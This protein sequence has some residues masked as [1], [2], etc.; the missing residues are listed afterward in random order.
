[1]T[2]YDDFLHCLD[3]IAD[4]IDWVLKENEK[5]NQRLTEWIK[6][7]YKLQ[8]E[9]KKLK[10]EICLLKWKNSDLDS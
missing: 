7:M 10:E 8:E 5:R 4:Y 1:M 9:N 3:L 2:N 6:R